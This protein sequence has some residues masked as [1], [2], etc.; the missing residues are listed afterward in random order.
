MKETLAYITYKGSEGI[1]I[2]GLPL[3]F[4]SLMWLAAFVVGWYIMAKMFKID[5]VS[6]D[7]LDPLFMYTFFGAVLGARIGEFLFYDPS[8]FIE[9]P[10][11]VFLPIQYSPGSEFLFGLIKNYKFVGFQGLASHGATVGLLISSYLYTRKYLP[12]KNMLWLVD[13]L[14]ICV[15]IGG[16]F[17]RIGNFVNSEIVGK[18]SDLP[19]AVLFEKQSLSY[20]EIVPRHPAQLY[21][22]FAYILL[23]IL[24][25]WIYNKTNKKYQNGYIFGLFFTLLFSIRFIIE[26]FKESQGV[27]WVAQTLKV[28]LN[29]GQ[30]LSIPFIIIGLV[31]MYLSNKGYFNKK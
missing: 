24:L 29:N 11:E 4:Y 28:N 14:A 9:R 31:V 6:K 26:F 25:W 13:R 3:H 22:A 30:V 21:E 7:K 27:E 23:F 16:A 17:V 5:G 1:E 18:P 10:L 8:A 20:G 19:W 12:G 15:S 2:F